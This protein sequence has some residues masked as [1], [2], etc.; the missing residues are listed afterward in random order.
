MLAH[1]HENATRLKETSVGH[2]KALDAQYEISQRV[3]P[4]VNLCLQ[5]LAQV[6]DY[7]QAHVPGMKAKVVEEEEEEKE[8][9]KEV[10]DAQK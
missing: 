7:I 5:E 3:E 1:L 6:T 4:M 10:V 2:A 9:E 8:K